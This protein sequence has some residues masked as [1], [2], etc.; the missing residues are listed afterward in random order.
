MILGRHQWSLC[1][2]AHRKECLWLWFWLWC[3]CDAWSWSVHLWRGNRSY[4][5]ARRKTRKTSLEAPI[6]CWRWWENI[7]MQ[8]NVFWNPVGHIFW[9][10]TPVFYLKGV[11][12]CP[13]TV[14]N[15]ETVSVA[16][17]ICRRG[18]S[19]FLSFGR[20][21]NSGTKLFNISGHVNHP[22]TVEEEMS[23]PLKEL[24]ERHAGIYY[25]EYI[26]GFNDP[27]GIIAWYIF[28]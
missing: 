27:A 2:W 18:G 19:W 23:I 3:V 26:Q 24:I 1:C 9:N 10:I 4:W 14:A 17:T 16:P 6:S 20:E 25:A 7:G 15:V 12:G 13:T 22:C 21:R 28:I 11:F 5:V 8:S